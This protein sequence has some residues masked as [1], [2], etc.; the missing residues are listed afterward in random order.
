MVVLVGSGSS[1]GFVAGARVM[2]PESGSR[3]PGSRS[4]VSAFSALLN[5]HVSSFPLLWFEG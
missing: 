4:W 5:F 2:D 3:F 1:K